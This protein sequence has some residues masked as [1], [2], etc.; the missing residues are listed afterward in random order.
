M[1]RGTFFPFTKK[2]SVRFT[3]STSVK[4]NERKKILCHRRREESGKKKKRSEVTYNL[5][6]KSKPTA[7]ADSSG[8]MVSSSVMSPSSVTPHKRECNGASEDCFQN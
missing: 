6:Q 8:T 4:K 5:K 2:D 3:A 1:T 7:T